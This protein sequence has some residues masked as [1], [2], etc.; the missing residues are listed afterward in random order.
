M[1]WHLCIDE[2][3]EFEFLLKKNSTSRIVGAC[4]TKTRPGGSARNS[5]RFWTGTV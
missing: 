3:G 1:T 4:V 2:T 5:S